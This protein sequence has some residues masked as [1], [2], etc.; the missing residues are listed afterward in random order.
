MISCGTQQP[1]SILRE[2]LGALR[3][4]GIAEVIAENQRQL[5]AWLAAR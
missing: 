3:D 2:F 4:T 1:D 5:N